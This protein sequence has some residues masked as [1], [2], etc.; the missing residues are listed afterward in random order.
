MFIAL[1]LRVDIQFT[2]WAIANR[3]VDGLPAVVPVY[4]HEFIVRQEIASTLSV[5]PRGRPEK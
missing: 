3:N 2:F 5:R 4:A 1:E